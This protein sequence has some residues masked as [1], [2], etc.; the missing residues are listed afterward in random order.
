MRPTTVVAWN[1]AALQAIRTTRPGPPMAARALAVVHT[2]IYDAWAA[3]D[4]VANGSRLGDELRRPGPERTEANKQQALSFAAHRALVD[5]F[6]SEVAAF[7]DLLARLGYD[8]D[9]AGDDTTPSG[10]GLLVADAV[11]AYRHG[12]GANQLGDLHPG[13]YSDYT[14]YQPMNDPDTV[15]DPNR[16]QPLRVAD[17][18]GG[19]TVQ[20]YVGP[21]WG[22]VTPFALGSGSAL[23]PRRGPRRYPGA[24]YVR[25]AEELLALSAD[26]TDERKAIAEYWAD[27]PD[28]EL[29]PGHWCLFAQWVSA[30]DA[31]GLDD[32]VRLFFALTG[33]L[34]DAGIAAWDAKRAFDSVRPVTAIHFL[35]AGEKVLAWAG[36]GQG[37]QLVRGEDW[38]PYQPVT[39]VTPPF[40]EY[41]SGHSSF[42]AAAAEILARFTGSDEFGATVTIPPGSSRVEPGQRPAAPVRL[43]WPTFTD[44]ADQAGRSRRYGGIHFRDGDLVGR[45]LGRLVAGRAWRTA[46]SLIE[47]TT[48]HRPW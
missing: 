47:G 24:G 28:S 16:W 35:F 29:P 20:R 8:P 9:R 2:A 48:R 21:H 3:F 22:L 40:P 46:W 44:A 6:P 32:D 4:D 45:V 13:A 11:L 31:H 37:T 25:Q 38:Q 18:R 43:S 34:L 15:R 12:D 42:S 27:G 19:A 5:L 33:A 10:V 7:D 23:R 39:V 17:G 26:L 36:P 14:G 41:V 30:R 1:Q